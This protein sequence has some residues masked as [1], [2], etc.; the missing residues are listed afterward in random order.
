M[1]NTISNV[2][3]DKILKFIYLFSYFSVQKGGDVI[4][5]NKRWLLRMI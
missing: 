5:W 4:E 3:S 1:L 2:L